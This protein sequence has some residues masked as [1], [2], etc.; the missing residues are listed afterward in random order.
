MPTRQRPSAH[1]GPR[2]RGSSLVE[3]MVVLALLAVLVGA[4][5]PGLEA[6]R[7]RRHLA[8]AAALLETDL[9][10]A[11]TAAV[12]RGSVLRLDF[13]STPAGGSCY[14]LH[15]GSAG[16]CSCTAAGEAPVCS[17]G[18]EAL[19]HAHYRAG[20]PVRLQSNSAS[21]AFEPH[22]GTVTPTATVRVVGRSG[23]AVHQIVNVMG[24]VRSCSPSLP[25]HPPC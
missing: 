25:G 17:A 2:V 19:R 12:A 3:A 13:A 8:G 23:Q 22:Q 16:A 15:T 7:E 21:I 20:L 5:V 11:R 24:R 6:M 4:A 10:L 14:V 9:Q 1:P 18:V